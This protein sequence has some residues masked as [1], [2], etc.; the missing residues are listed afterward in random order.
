MSLGSFGRSKRSCNWKVKEFLPKLKSIEEVVMKWPGQRIQENWKVLWKN[1]KMSST[2]MNVLRYDKR[3]W[4]PPWSC[5]YD[6]KG[7]VTKTLNNI[8][9]LFWWPLRD[10]R[11]FCS[12]I[13]PISCKGIDSTFHSLRIQFPFFF[14]HFCNVL[15]CLKKT[16]TRNT[17]NVELQWNYPWRRGSIVQIDVMCVT[18]FLENKSLH[19]WQREFPKVQWIAFEFNMRLL[20]SLMRI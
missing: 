20:F 12:L 5:H 8:P 14:G 10:Y 3:M 6:I 17:R 18:F 1:V 15:K 19:H 7:S 9:V 4:G 13:A 2:I 16:E 11:N